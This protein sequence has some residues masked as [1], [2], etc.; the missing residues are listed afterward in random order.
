MRLRVHGP[1]LLVAALCAASCDAQLS[2]SMTGPTESSTGLFVSLSGTSSTAFAQ[3]VNDFRCPSISPFTVP[4]V[5]VVSPA[6]AAIPVVTQMRL[7]FIDQSGLRM[8]Q[9][10]LPAP[11]PTTEFGTALADS[12]AQAF[13]LSVGIGCD[14][15][16]TGNL[17]IVVD[18]RDALGHRGSSQTTVIVR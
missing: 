6:G 12:R 7:Q 9:V 15:G 17:V 18:T 14:T 1:V 16:H 10:T 13:A 8:P 2:R 11:I 4:I 5:V 3:R